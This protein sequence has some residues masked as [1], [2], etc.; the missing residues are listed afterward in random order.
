MIRNLKAITVSRDE[1]E[2]EIKE[3]KHA[4]EAEKQ[5]QALSKNVIDSIPGTFYML[6]ENGRYVRWNNYQRDEIVGKS[7]SQIGD[8]NAIDTIHPD[9]RLL[10]SSRIANV[11]KNGR[12]E[13]VEG[14]VL[15]RGGPTFRWFL[16]TGRQIIIKGSSFLI[17]TGID[18]TDRKHTEK[19]RDK[20]ILKLQEA[21]DKVKTLSGMLPICA[22]CKK[23]KD[24]KGN[25][26]QIEVYI[27]DRTETIFSHGICPE[28]EKTLYPEFSGKEHAKEENKHG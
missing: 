15:L 25:W 26:N 13:I 23:I 16:M 2:H 1:L 24:D 28:C 21:L 11:L 5:E 20:V 27:R 7:E 12:E 8:T 22:N 4:Q 9:D 3:R 6:D 10:I 18:I 17:G 19:E 14:R